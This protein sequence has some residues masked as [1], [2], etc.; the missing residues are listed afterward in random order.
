MAMFPAAL[1]PRA[2]EIRAGD[3][4]SQVVEKLLEGAAMMRGSTNTFLNWGRHYASLADDAE[5]GD[6]TD[7]SQ[8]IT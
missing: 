3:A 8:P 5:A 2:G 4:N 7:D 6:D 1:E